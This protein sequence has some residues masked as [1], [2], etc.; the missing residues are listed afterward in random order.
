MKPGKVS[1]PVLIRSIIK[2]IKKQNDVILEGAAVGNDAA[3][4]DVAG[5]K[6]LASTETVTD[7]KEY[8]KA[9][10]FIRSVNNCLAK[11]GIPISAQVSIVI[12]ENMRESG[13]KNIMEE[14]VFAAEKLNCPISGGHTEVSSYVQTPVVTV[15]TMAAVISDIGD[16]LSL[17]N[18]KPGQD[19]VVT[20]YIGLEGSAILAMKEMEFFK[21]K[22]SSG[23]IDN[24]LEYI[25]EISIYNEAAVASKHGVTAMH[26][27][28]ENG[29]FGALWE[30]GEAGNCGVEIDLRN[31]P[32]HQETIELCEYFDINPYQMPSS[33]ALLIITD[34]GKALKEKYL[35]VGINAQVIGTTTLGNDKVI[36][37]N[38]ERRYL[39]PPKMEKM[40]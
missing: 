5:R 26:D 30:I 2:P 36:V 32:V 1:E 35:S 20:N 28:S 40:V 8:Q 33:G 38:E 24:I 18:I 3:L 16:A 10:A 15:T 19:I 9:R 6:I 39:E 25:N 23:Y 21:T 13:L 12:P 4:I 7:K 29:I 37:N 34:D 27:L 22:F 11:G 17:K 14:M 31:I